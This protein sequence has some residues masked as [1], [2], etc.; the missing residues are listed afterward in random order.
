MARAWTTS[1][2][3]PRLELVGSF[4]GG[5][6]RQKAQAVGSSGAHLGVVDDEPEVWVRGMLHDLV[7]RGEVTQVGV[8][9]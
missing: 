9:Q 5:T 3:R 7:G 4:G 6:A 8:V 1:R 2:P